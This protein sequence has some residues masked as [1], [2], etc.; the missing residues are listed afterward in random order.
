M[1]RQRPRVLGEKSSDILEKKEARKYP[2]EF[3]GP[4]K[5]TDR[6]EISLPEGYEV[7]ELPPPVDVDYPFGSYQSR[8]AVQG[9][10]IV[11]TR[12]FEIKK[13]SVPLDLTEELKRFYCVIGGDE[14][15]TAVLKPAGK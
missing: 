4:R 14:R 1:L 5:D 15:S 8:T 3:E 6:I 12:V 10:S 11:Y 13:V 2:V 9:K 7:D